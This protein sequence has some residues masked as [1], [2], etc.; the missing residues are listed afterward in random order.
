[1]SF[2]C[3]WKKVWTIHGGSGQVGTL[4]PKDCTFWLEP[5]DV[6]GQ[7]VYYTMH[8]ESGVHACLNG[9]TL[10]PVGWKDLAHAPLQP[11]QENCPDIAAAYQKEADHIG[12]VGGTNPVAKRLEGTFTYENK[13]KI[14]TLVA[15]IYCFPGGEQGR[16]DWLV[17]DV[18]AEKLTEEDGTAH[19]DA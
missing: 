12:E 3:W 19:G 4:I 5:V 7:T 2:D 6:N 16:K 1:M 18:I 14:E 11:W 13:N 8:P 15:R 17:F 9:L 10:Y